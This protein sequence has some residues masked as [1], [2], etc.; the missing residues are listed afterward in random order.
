[1]GASYGICGAKRSLERGNGETAISHNSHARLEQERMSLE[2]AVIAGNTANSADFLST[3]RTPDAGSP[4]VRE[5]TYGDRVQKC[6][7]NPGA[8]FGR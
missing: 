6:P 2:L 7:R 4:P 3:E 5:W 1:M 8:I